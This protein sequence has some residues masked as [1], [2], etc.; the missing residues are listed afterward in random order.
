MGLE[1]KPTTRKSSKKTLFVSILLLALGLTSLV[2]GA[3]LF[4]FNSTTDSEGYALSDTIPINTDSHAFVLQLG[5][6]RDSYVWMG[7]SNIAQG[8]WTVTSADPAKEL[9]V[10][11]ATESSVSPYI[12][13][14]SFLEPYGTWDWTT[15]A[16]YADVQ[17]PITHVA[18][19]GAPTTV[20]AGENFWMTTALTS[21]NAPAVLHW[22][23]VWD[24]S[25]GRRVLVVMNADGSSNVQ[26]TLSS[27]LQFPF[28]AG[29][30]TCSCRWESCFVWGAF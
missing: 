16:Y 18:G 17:L 15:H 6:R 21:A 14:F 19:E 27:A 11:W 13:L 20:P 7:V 25:E 12:N 28:S 30:H 29:C 26:A 4:Y 23:A 10:G 2:G 5:P 8:K 24:A 22:D 9:F 1:T 3:V